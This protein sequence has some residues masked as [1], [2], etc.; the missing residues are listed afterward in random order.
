MNTRF[1]VGEVSKLSD[2]PKQTLIYYDKEDVFKPK[3]ID[4]NNGYRYY[5]ADQIEVLDSILI[6]KE[7]GLSLKEI[8]EFMRSRNSENAVTLMK[9]QYADINEKINRLKTISRRLKH[10]LETLEDFYEDQQNTVF[11][12][13]S[14]PEY[15]AIEPV[16]CPNGLLEVDIALKRLLNKAENLKYPYYYQI[17]DMVSSENLRK[18]NYVCFEYAF[19]P[20]EKVL[21]NQSVFKKNKG[22]YARCYHSGA[23][24]EMGNTYD[25]LLKVIR[26][27]GFKPV[28][29]SY[30]YCVL[31]SL[32]SKKAD[33]YITEIQLQVEKL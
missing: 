7:M 10:K 24:S 8:K 16:D 12:N 4:P 15:L 32:T 23:Y 33:D 14:K 27:S 29:Y 31:D 28:G 5:T 9:K 21:K 6:L 30:E 13:I 20:L 17:G 2:I 3:I 11:I 19:L 18:R 26:D 22:L 25:N 1:T